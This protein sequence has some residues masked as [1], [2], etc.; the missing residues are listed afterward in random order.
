MCVVFPWCSELRKLVAGRPSWLESSCFRGIRRDIDPMRLDLPA[1]TCLL[2]AGPDH[3]AVSDHI[4]CQELH[5][6]RDEIDGHGF[7]SSLSLN[8]RRR[9]NEHATNDRAGHR[10]HLAFSTI[11]PPSLRSA[12]GGSL[13]RCGLTA[14]VVNR[15][16]VGALDS[17]AGPGT[18]SNGLARSD[19]HGNTPR[20]R[21]SVPAML[22]RTASEMQ[23]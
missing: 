20:R 3:A 11:A 15:A 19:A 13:V 10:E 12:L 5:N 9:R 6:E 22:R 8:L 4:G 23:H 17:D 14:A 16:R 21:C 1:T 7:S 18:G 2:R